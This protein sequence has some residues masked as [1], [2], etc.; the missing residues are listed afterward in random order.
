M[1]V[2]IM[3]YE[4]AK[5]EV[6]ARESNPYIANDKYV[7]GVDRAWEGWG[8]VREVYRDL[9]YFQ[10]TKDGY[11]LP[12]YLIANIT[13]VDVLRYGEI[14]I[15]EEIYDYCRVKAYDEPVCVRLRVISY[16]GSLYWLKQEDGEIVEF[17][18]I[19]L[20]MK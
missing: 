16:N 5:A 1:K 4:T 13:S 12:N 11:Q 7:Y 17:K 18:E 6:L 15:D 2:K 3:D 10:D 20:A 8:K 9:E 19:G 14:I